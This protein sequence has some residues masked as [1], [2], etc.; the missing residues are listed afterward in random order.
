[1][2]LFLCFEHFCVFRGI[3]EKESLLS[4]TGFLEIQQSLI[5]YLN[6]FFSKILWKLVCHYYFI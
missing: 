2:L 3:W 1:M 6:I 4:R 5:L